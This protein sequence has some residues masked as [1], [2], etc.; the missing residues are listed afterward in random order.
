MDVCSHE[1]TEPKAGGESGGRPPNSRFILERR[2]LAPGRGDHRFVSSDSMRGSFYCTIVTS[3]VTVLEVRNPVKDKSRYADR[4][5]T[6][7]P[8]VAEHRRRQ[9]SS[10]VAAIVDPWVPV[11]MEIDLN[12]HS[13]VGCNI[14]SPERTSSSSPS[15]WA[16]VDRAKQ[17]RPGPISRMRTCECFW[18]AGRTNLKPSDR[19]PSVNSI[20]NHLPPILRFTAEVIDTAEIPNPS[21]HRFTRLWV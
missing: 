7:R 21:S 15:P 1:L 16:G 9:N 18:H 14:P 5:K 3:R 8:P 6:C 13:L 12:V 17:L 10:G 2:R 19:M 11:C 4:A 20:R